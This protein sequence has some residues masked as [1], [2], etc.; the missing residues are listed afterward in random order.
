MSSGCIKQQIIIW[1]CMFSSVCFNTRVLLWFY[2]FTAHLFIFYFL[3]IYFIDFFTVRKGEEE[4]IRNIDERETSISCLPYTPYWGCALNQRTWPLPG[5][6][7]GTLES[8]G[9]RSIH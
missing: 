4:R 1:K 5:I 7:P 2:S 3:K 8:V 9:R 6:E